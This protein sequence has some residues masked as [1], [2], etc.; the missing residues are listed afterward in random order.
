MALGP[1]VRVIEVSAIFD[2]RNTLKLRKTCKSSGV[3]TVTMGPT[4]LK[5]TSN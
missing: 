1:I 5:P 4:E 3:I 2:V